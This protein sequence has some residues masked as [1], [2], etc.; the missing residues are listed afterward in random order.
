M[1]KKPTW[2][3]PHIYN[4]DIDYKIKYLRTCSFVPYFEN[5]IKLL[6]NY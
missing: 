4:V 2:P 5:D 6:K 1:G 3:N